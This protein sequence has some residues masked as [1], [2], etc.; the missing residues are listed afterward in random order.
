MGRD[1]GET[2]ADF[3]LVTTQHH[4]VLAHAPSLALR[5]AEL[6]LGSETS[7]DGEGGRLEESSAEDALWAYGIL[8]GDGDMA[9]FREERG[10]E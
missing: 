10:D 6:P 4:E 3:V 9:I 8:H 2:K 1:A 5:D 7:Q